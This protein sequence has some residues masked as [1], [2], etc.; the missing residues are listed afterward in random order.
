MADEE[1][2]ETAPE[3][4]QSEA[5]ES[6]EAAPQEHAE[7]EPSGPPGAEAG[8]AFRLDEDGTLHADFTPSVNNVA[9]DGDALRRMLADAGYGEVCLFREK[10]AELIRR[11]RDSKEPF[12]LAIGGHRDGAVE[13]TIDERGAAA[14]AQLRHPCGEGRAVDDAMI[15]EALTA[16]GVTEGWLEEEFPRLIKDQGQTLTDPVVIARGVPPADG[17]DTR[18]ESLVPDAPERRPRNLGDEVIDY[19][20]FGGLVTVAEGDPLV[21]RQPPT[22]G[23]AGRTVTGETIPPRPGRNIDFKTDS[24]VRVSEE[25]PDTLVAAMGGMPVVTDTGAKV[26]QVVELETVDLST[27]HIDFDGTV[28]V[29]GDVAA[30]MRITATGDINVGGTVEA[31]RLEADGDITVNGGILGRG[32]VRDEHGE[33]RTDAGYVGAGGSVHARFIQNT[34]V[35]AGDSVLAKDMLNNS[36]VTC[37]NQVIVGG[38]GGSGKAQIVGGLTRATAKVETSILGSPRSAHTRVEVG[39]DHAFHKRMR[40]CRDA[41]ADKEKLLADV[42]R[43]LNYY[44]SY[45]DKARQAEKAKPGLLK[46]LMATQCQAEE[47]RQELEA[48]RE[49]L[50]ADLEHI[51]RARV[52]VRK[53]VYSNVTL[54]FGPKSR[55]TDEDIPEG[56]VFTL[57][58]QWITFRRGKG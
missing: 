15:R 8:L 19:R 10:V 42:E 36:E 14:E 43:M 51:R 54:I 13:I 25:D 6:G 4:S 57:Q 20:E 28:V 44:K 24:T 32:N 12:S 41:L 26:E 38:R 29:K 30:A 27:G 5:A 55:T 45:P 7:G 33:A 49:E 23:E 40:E 16:A 3:G 9:V 48:S 50:E 18:F 46:R 31:S 37:E 53:Q 56:G 39:Y 22:E 35:E 47:E 58:D 52:V 21:R 11:Q 34:M 17:E 1:R 2:P